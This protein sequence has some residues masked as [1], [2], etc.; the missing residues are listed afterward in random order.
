MRESDLSIPVN[1]HNFPAD[2]K[3]PRAEPIG[4]DGWQPGEQRRFGIQFTKSLTEEERRDIA[5]FLRDTAGLSLDAYISKWIYLELVDLETLQRVSRHPLFN[6]AIPFAAEYKISP[7]I[8]QTTPPG[9]RG[10]RLRAAL[11]PEADAEAVAKDLANLGAWEIDVLDLRRRGGVARIEFTLPSQTPVEAVAA[12]PAVSWIEPVTEAVPDSADHLGYLETGTT[13]SAPLSAAGITGHD[14]IIGVIDGGPLNFTH[15]WFKDEPDNT[16]GT[17]HR[18]MRNNRNASNRGLSTHPNFV[19]G[20]LAGDDI[21]QPPGTA[22]DRGIACHAR[23]SYSNRRDFG[24]PGPG[25]T[26]FDY[27]LDAEADGACIHTNSWHFPDDP[28][29]TL[30]AYD[31]DT[32]TWDHEDCLVVA[33]S[34]NR[35]EKVGPPGAAK[36]ALCVSAAYIGPNAAGDHVTCFADGACKKNAAG[37][38]IPLSDNRRR[39]E[40]LAPGCMHVSAGE[41]SICKTRAAQ[42]AGAKKPPSDGCAPHDVY[43]A[44]SYATPVV[45]A[46]AAIARQYLTAGYYPSGS[47]SAAGH[48]PTGALLKALLLNATAATNSGFGYPN[49]RE[50]WGL[51]QLDRVLPLANGAQRLWFRDIRHA[52]GPAGGGRNEETVTL[53]PASEPLKVTLVWSDPPAETFSSLDPVVNNLDLEVI[54]PDGTTFLGNRFSGGESL[55]GGTALD[56]DPRNNVEMVLVSTPAAGD[57][58]IVVRATE[59]NFAPTGQGYALVVTADLV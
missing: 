14:Q 47:P 21:G 38:C 50:G 48:N 31:A 49:D 43:C 18:K 2:G 17:G 54:A 44:T 8:A 25:H 46:A 53:Q 45:A 32:F 4:D 24:F 34:G 52:G 51:L 42:N 40:I 33:S 22:F 55:A 1:L 19:C 56:T 23:I 29:Y 12:I 41:G 26:F 28:A 7:G 6:A 27:L 36:N 10:R 39:P 9:D 16:P 20:V 35:N 11:F 15:C 3:D 37:A 30:I 58:T 13:T 57:W 59:V 5:A